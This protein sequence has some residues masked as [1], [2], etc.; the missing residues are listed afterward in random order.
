MKNGYRCRSEIER[1]NKTTYCRQNSQ[2][3]D[4]DVF[5][6]L[7]IIRSKGKRLKIDYASFL[8]S[9]GKA[10]MRSFAAA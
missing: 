5:E 3:V 2:R 1:R 7:H 9:W 8:A 10:V 6:H 4:H